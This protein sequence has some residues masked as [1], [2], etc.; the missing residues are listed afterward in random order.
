[1]YREF[2]TEEFEVQKK[3]IEF[4]LLKSQLKLESSQKKFQQKELT[5]EAGVNFINVYARIFRT[6]F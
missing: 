4:Q 6:K 2:S 1:M 5:K 3:R